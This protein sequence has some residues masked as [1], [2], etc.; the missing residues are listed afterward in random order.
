MTNDMTK[1]TPWKLILRFVVPVALGNI[2]QQVYAIVDSVIV[3][4]YVGVNALAAVGVTGPL[5]FI[6]IGWIM[7]MTSGFSILVAQ[8]YGAGDE[9]RLRHYTAMS[10]YLCLGLAAV[11]TVGCLM[12]N[13]SL[14]RLMNTPAHI[15]DD[16]AVYIGIIYAGLA[17]TIAYN[18]L[19]GILRAL[20]DSRTPLYFLIF[21]SILNII[22]DLVFIRI[23]HMGV[24]GAAWATVISQAA[25][26]VFC[27]VFMVKKY[28]I[29]R[30]DK[31]EGKFSRDSFRRLMAMGIP[32]ALQ[33]SIT[34]IG[35]MIVQ[36]ALNPLGEIPIAAFTAASKL[37]TLAAQQIMSALGVGMATYVGQ[38]WGAGNILRVRQGVRAG[39][40]LAV[41][42]GL[43]S[44]LMITV[45][46]DLGVQ[47]FIKENV[48]EVTGYAVQ[49]F[50]IVKWFFVPMA[51][52]FIFRNSLQGLGDGL[53]PML[54]GV[55]EL[56]ARGVGVMLLVKPLGF[57][58]IALTDPC[59]W[60][61]A[62]LPIVPV[63]VLRMRKLQGKR[64]RSI[65]SEESKK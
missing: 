8:S 16:T 47:M 44:M 61:A 30:F 57:T 35:V 6:V 41:L 19:S 4:R 64:Q 36:G 31:E 24:A 23:F 12:A 2:F 49:Y 58:G 33:F 34:G 25:S 59:A 13:R 55:F 1:G 40:V 18:M 39:C 5:T 46:G 32:M 56:I 17:A 29:L 11:M 27:F 28:R 62:L 63:Y 38:N 14:L 10:L 60:L 21:S 50:G 42:S 53:F 3:G 26:A 43:L 51:L 22:L 45:L 52:I 7:G 9:K 15:M 54:G 48:A 65:G 37:Q 20:G